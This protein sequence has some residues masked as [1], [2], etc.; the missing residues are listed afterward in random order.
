M[1][2]STSK[3]ELQQALQKLSKATPTRSTLPILG[4]V[5]IDSGNN[6]TIL[7]TTDLEISIQVEIPSSLEKSG[8]AA[9]PLK[10]LLEVTNELPEVR[11]TIEVDDKNKAT[12]ST[13]VGHYDLM[14]K[15]ADEFPKTPEQ[16]SPTSITIPGKT[17]KHIIDSTSFAI[18]RDEL[19]P[20]LTGVLLQITEDKTI[21]VSTDGHRLVKQTRGDFGSGGITADIIVPKKFLSYLSS[22][23]RDQD[24]ELL[25]AEDHLAAR[26]G[27][28]VVITR[29]I[30]ESFPNYESVIPKE[31]NKRLVVEKSALLGAIKR[32]SIFSNKSTHQVALSLSSDGCK[33]TTEDPEKSSKAQ[34]KIPATFEGEPLVIGYNAEYL[35]DVVSHIDGEEVAI[36]LSSS[37]SAAL[38]S[39]LQPDEKIESIMLLMPIRLND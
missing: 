32:V 31:N 1:K 5:L 21:A 17:L 8:Q 29:I 18:S 16:K 30:D 26:V 19:K 36:D 27:S 22:H 2:F 24:V 39:S 38:F 28:D 3:T 14:A 7:K 23:L 4:C 33:I 20:A 9:I 10:T 15:I 37:V 25:L 34:E 13:D 35:K 6:K 11:L 12:I